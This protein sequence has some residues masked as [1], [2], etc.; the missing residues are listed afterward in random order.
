MKILNYDKD[1]GIFTWKERLSQ[2]ANIGSVAGSVLKTNKSTSY[3]RIKIAGKSYLAHR[4]AWLYCNDSVMGIIDHIDRNG[5]NNSLSNLRL[6][7]KK[8]NAKNQKL[9]SDN[10]SGFNGVYLHHINKK[11]V[12]Y[13]TENKKMKYIGSFIHKENAINARDTENKNLGF[14]NN[15]GVS[16]SN[17]Q[18]NSF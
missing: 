7:T 4:L 15:H 9:R 11:W 10:T 8:G 6:T 17:T 3:L 1:T 18:L 16:P 5:L 12:A 2:R 14:D 13:V